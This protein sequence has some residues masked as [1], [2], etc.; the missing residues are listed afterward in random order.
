MLRFAS[1]LILSRLLFPEAFGMMAIV[2]ALHVGV[3][4]LTDVGIGQSIVAHKDGDTAAFLDT[5]WVLQ[6]IKGVFVAT[7]MAMG[8]G[9]AAD[10]YGNSELRPLVLIVALSALVGGFN[11]TKLATADRQ[12][13]ARQYFLLAVGAQV[14]ALAVTIGL[15]ILNQGASSIAWGNFA[16][17][18]LTCALSHF[19]LVGRVNRFR[20]ERRHVPDI[21]SFGAMILISSGLTFVAGEGSK[22]FLGSLI[23]IRTLGIFGIAMSLSSI[24]VGAIQ[25]LSARVLFPAYAQTHRTNDRDALYRVVGKGRNTQLMAMWV[26]SLFF[27]VFGQW[28]VS[29]LYDARYAEAGF[30]LQCLAMGMLVGALTTSYAG[31]L[32]A[33]GRPGLQLIIVGIHAAAIWPCIFIGHQLLGATGAVIGIAASNWLCYPFVVTL[34][35]RLGLSYLKVDVPVLAASLAALVVFFHYNRSALGI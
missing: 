24:A 14:F 32:M 30:M 22:L 6:I 11:S 21:L 15:A 5:A 10:F 7:A 29:H 20:L 18:A 23:D 27:V 25:A 13:Q 19:Y 34:F 1:T 8:A 9:W 12:M 35:S 16:G 26:S 31:V 4:M 17:A 33:I 28:I 3:V 2:I